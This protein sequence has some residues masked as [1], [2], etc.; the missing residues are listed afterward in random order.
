VLDRIGGRPE[1]AH[2]AN[3][4]C[5]RVAPNSGRASSRCACP[6]GES[7]APK[8]K[9]VR[10]LI[11]STCCHRGRL[12]HAPSRR[13]RKRRGRAAWA[14][15]LVKSVE[16]RCTVDQP[17]Q[18][19]RT[20]VGRTKGLI[21]AI[22]SESVNAEIVLRVNALCDQPL[23][24]SSRRQKSPGAVQRVLWTIRGNSGLRIALT[25]NPLVSHFHGGA[26]FTHIAPKVPRCDYRESVESVHEVVLEK[27]MP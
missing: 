22:L 10:R 9:P 8:P 23:D 7:G 13:A 26:F 14:Q 19:S 27:V 25:A 6:A 1:F 2:R 3:R 24:R 12:Q 20:S 4:A 18:L 11:H 17:S 21:R 16:N 15:H 5:R